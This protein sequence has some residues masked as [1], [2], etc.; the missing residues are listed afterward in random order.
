MARLTL[1]T[2]DTAPADS[3]PFVEKAIANNGYLP[4]LIGVLA[5]APVALETYLTVAGINGRASL[6]LA[7]R[8]VVQITAARIH[9]CD[10]CVAGHSAV[11][12]KKAGQPVETVRALQHGTA[13][14]DSKLD[15]VAAFA[16][17]V[18]ATRGAVGDS[19]YQAFIGAGYHEQQALEVVLGISLATLCNFANSLAGTP[20]NPQLT[21]YL[22][23]AI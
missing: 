15:A 4:N 20:V 16:S 6:S 14:G 13:T 18:I 5:N 2:L 11:A 12:L 17:A 19:A 21:P 3:R 22:P 7:E 10:F 8:E 23:G 1:H 9:G